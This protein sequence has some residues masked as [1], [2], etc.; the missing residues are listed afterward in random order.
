M[1]DNSITDDSSWG[2]KLCPVCD[3]NTI[4]QAATKCLKCHQKHYQASAKGKEVRKAAI[5]RFKAKNP[6]SLK[7]YQDKYQASDKGKETRKAAMKRFYAKHPNYKR[8]YN[9]QLREKKK[10]E[11]EA[12]KLQLV[13]DQERYKHL[14]ELASNWLTS[15]TICDLATC[16]S[17]AKDLIKTLEEV[18]NATT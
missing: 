8:E 4:S 2:D 18:S 9:R 14:K 15:M 7:D 3:I 10:A 13:Q 6:K 16:K 17:I 1:K 11:L 5:E 12:I